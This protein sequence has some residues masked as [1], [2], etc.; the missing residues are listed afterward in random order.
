M[1][2]TKPKPG[3]KSRGA[4]AGP[5]GI[6]AASLVRADREG[7][8]N[9]RLHDVADDLGIPLAALRATFRDQ[10]AIADAWFR[11]ALD[12][13]LGPFEKSFSDLPAKERLYIVIMRWFDALA[14]HR[15]AT[16]EMIRTKLYPAHPHHWAPL[17]FNLS[18]LVQWV[19]EAA[20]LDAQGRRRQV[21]EIGLTA[22]MVAAIG[23]WAVDETPD[24]ERTRRFLRRR[25]EAADMWMARW[26]ARNG[27]GRGRR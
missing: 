6:V 18:R 23:V 26:F 3:K 8:Q 22:L 7:W 15:P 17:V 19:R 1:A 12:A 5:E 11:T 13:M 16:V 2:A 24:Q 25:L 9:L 10:D 27:G 4:D 21:E 14:D 20:R